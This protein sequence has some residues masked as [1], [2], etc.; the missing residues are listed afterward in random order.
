MVD[1]CYAYH[2]MIWFLSSS[3]LH[4]M[5]SI[6]PAAMYRHPMAHLPVNGQELLAW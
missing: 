1:G 5:Q 6:H 3:E 4:N 2:H